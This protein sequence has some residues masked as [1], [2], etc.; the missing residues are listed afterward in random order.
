MNTKI[1]KSLHFRIFLIIIIAIIP[2]II[3]S[4]YHSNLEKVN[5]KKELKNQITQL[6]RIA[7]F[8]EEKT[9]DAARQLLISIA[10]LPNEYFTDFVR[11]KR[12]LI[13]LSRQYNR[14]INFGIVNRNGLLLV[15]SRKYE[16]I[17]DYSES[18]FFKEALKYRGFSIGEY[19]VDSIS[20][21]SVIN[22]GYP[23]FDKKGNINAVIFTSLD[24]SYIDLI[25]IELIK[26][27]HLYSHFIKIENDGK[28]ISSN[29]Y[30]K[31]LIRKVITPKLINTILEQETGTIE[32][33][34]LDKQDY[35]FVFTST[36]SNL[37]KEELYLVVGITKESLYAEINTT[38]YRNLVL[39][40]V[41]FILVLSVVTYLSNKY[42][43]RSIN[44]LV[45]V[46]KEIA[47]Q[48]FS[49][50]TNIREGGEELK[51]LSVT[52]D[53]MADS[54]ERQIKARESAEQQLYLVLK[55]APV[56]IFTIDNNGIFK[57]I[58]G[59][60]LD[61][62][63]LKSNEYIGFSAFEFFKNLKVYTSNNIITNGEDIIKNS[64]KGDQNRII[65]EYNGAY[66]DTQLIPLY[67]DNN[68]IE[69]VVVIGIDVTERQQAEKFLR[70][71]E[72][73]FH[74]LFEFAPIALLREDFSEFKVYLDKLRANGIEDFES[75]FFKHPEE[76][77]NCVSMLRVIDVNNFS[78]KLFNV[79]KQ[80]E[81]LSKLISS[82]NR[83]LFTSFTKK[84]NRILGGENVFEAEIATYAVTGEKSFVILKLLILPGYEETW[85]KV[86]IA[87]TDITGRIKMESELRESHDLFLNTIASL[88]DAI[89]LIDQK[90]KL[91]IYC[92][93]AAEKIFGYKQTEIF[94]QSP[95]I[96]FPN[97]IMYNEFKQKMILEIEQKGLFQ[98]EFKSKKKNGEIFPS[99]HFIRPIMNVEGKTMVILHV[100]GNISERKQAQEIIKYQSTLFENVHDAILATDKDL[101]ITAWN[102]AAEELYG[103]SANEVIGKHINEVLHSNFLSDEN[104]KSLRLLNRGELYSVKL[105][106]Y[107]KNNR[108]VYVEG[109]TMALFDQNNNLTGYV[110]INRDITERIKIEKEKEKL[111]LEVKETSEQLKALSRRLIEIQEME[112]K[113]IAR[114]MHDE[115][116]QTL[117]AIKINLQS[118]IKLAKS[119]KVKNSLAD[120]IDLTDK[121]LQQVRNLSL[122]LHPSILDDLGLVP[123]INWF[124]KQIASSTMLKIHFDAE[125]KN[126]SLDKNIEITCYRIVQEAVNNT[127]KHAKAKNV[128]L[129]LV[130]KENSVILSIKDD[131]ISFDVSS[132]YKNALGGKSLGILSMEERVKLLGGN[133]EIISSKNTGTQINVIF[134]LRKN[135]SGFNS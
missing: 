87:I 115:I 80:D 127:V 111:F 132:A 5:K 112:R 60:G 97:E 51:Q 3:L 40:G 100:I 129:K 34:G 119:P 69:G 28:I 9:I 54:L 73:Q 92:N 83:E 75:Y 20:G 25:E 26:I 8:E 99:E 120:S 30:P 15:S 79:K 46:T 86:L 126:I 121:T 98:T 113:N 27:F 17:K 13:N 88:N 93:P 102:L 81:I 125:P 11:I 42:I 110:S 38:L 90:T 134:N 128:F 104:E 61:R 19:Y 4:I 52:F 95:G 14:Y 39:I 48:N 116:G 53:K 94:N 43:L 50:R 63:G 7:A 56:I 91:I 85:S 122:N 108:P 117:T 12:H 44:K 33:Q 36:N 16:K 22:F 1:L 55:N 31:E 131:G 74:N 32:S 65:I 107:K 82:F 123:A 66:F 21:K 71:S 62:I 118:L 70:E 23:L 49:L 67:N 77:V 89:F 6:V 59:N 124:I 68:I 24:V 135:S 18:E 37:F 133:F 41:I 130:K 45:T 2:F 96:L 10:S 29:I 84:I 76:I 109:T 101:K 114:E 35:L 57:F 58:E 105:L 64:V 106:Q 47:N 103:W 78:L 72:Q